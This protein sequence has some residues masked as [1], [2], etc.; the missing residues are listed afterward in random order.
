MKY[1]DEYACFDYFGYESKK[2][3]R[4]YIHKIDGEWH[5]AEHNELEDPL[6]NDHAVRDIGSSWVTTYDSCHVGTSKDYK[7][8]GADRYPI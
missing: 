4:A 2:E 8:Q 3:K 6:T 5:L 7:L 1:A